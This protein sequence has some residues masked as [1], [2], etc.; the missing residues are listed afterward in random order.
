M[1]ESR[2]VNNSFPEALKEPI[3]RRIQFATTS[4]VDNLGMS[5]E[6]LRCTATKLIVSFH[7]VDEVYEVR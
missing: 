6:A 4:R 5:C 3:L 7:A 1:E 2:E